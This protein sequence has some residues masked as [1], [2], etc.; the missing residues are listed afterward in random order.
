MIFIGEVSEKKC[1]LVDSVKNSS[2]TPGQQNQKDSPT[3][4]SPPVVAPSSMASSSP[5]LM[6]NVFMPI[7]LDRTFKVL[8]IWNIKLLPRPVG[9]NSKNVL[10]FSY[11]L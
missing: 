4:R 7:R 9:K 10:L 3:V 8:S 1:T 5:V 11:R 6:A 2:S